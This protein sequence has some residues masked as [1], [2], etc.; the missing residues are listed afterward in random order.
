MPIYN[1]WCY[2]CK[3]TDEAF[4]TMSKR[5][6]EGSGDCPKC[7]KCRKEMTRDHNMGKTGRQTSTSYGSGFVSDSLAMNPDQIEEHGKLFPDV[8]V[9]SDGRPV[10]TSYKQHDDYLKKTGFQKLPQKIKGL[11]SVRIAGT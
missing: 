2:D 7:P 3:T 11:G 4:C 9:L 8:Q 6:I 5:P 10:F 1:Y